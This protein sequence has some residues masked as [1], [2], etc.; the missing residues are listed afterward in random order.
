MTKR[1]TPVACCGTPSGGDGASDGSEGIKRDLSMLDDC[2][3][4]PINEPTLP[5]VKGGGG[6]GGGRELVAS[7]GVRRPLARAREVNGA[8]VAG[9]RLA[10]AEPWGGYQAHMNSAHSLKTYPFQD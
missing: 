1:N 8:L 2:T 4:W 6:S 10:R 7:A 5:A 3:V 9:G